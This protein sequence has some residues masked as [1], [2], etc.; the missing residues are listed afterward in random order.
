MS[1]AKMIMM[2]GRRAFNISPAVSGKTLWDLDNDGPLSLGSAGTWVITPVSTF[3]APTKAWGAGATL[4]TFG[5]G[6]AGGYATG[7]VLLV[8]GQSYTLYVGAPNSGVTGGA[9]GGGDGSTS[10]SFAGFGGAGYS[11]LHLTSGLV[12]VLIAG[13]GGGS[14][15]GSNGGAGGGATGQ[16]GQD[17]TVSGPFGGKGGSSSAG[18]VGGDL[19][20]G[21]SSLNGGDSGATAWGGGGGGGYYG[22]GSS[23]VGAGGTA[24]GGG[25]GSAYANPQYVVSATLTVGSGTTPG[26][27][28]DTDRA[29]AGST[30]TAGLV[31]LA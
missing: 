22:G 14:G 7:H 24:G 5:V 10:V 21:G 3:L 9:P 11:G 2:F 31:R 20:G 23:G 12:P 19:G 8:S 25:G 4:G 30:N 28:A 26:N 17:I 6:G 16:D 1:A 13:G 15:R 29:G 18:G 27:S